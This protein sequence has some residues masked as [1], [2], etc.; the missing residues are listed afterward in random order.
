M[1]RAMVLALL[2][3]A[4]PMAAWADGIDLSNQFG[5]I[6]RFGT[7]S[8]S[9]SGIVSR[10]SQLVRFY[11]V[12]AAPGHSLGLV[13]FTTGALLSGSIAGGGTFAGGYGMSS[14]IVIGK[15]NWGE[16]KGTIFAGYFRSPITWTLISQ[17]G[18][19]LVFQLK[20]YVRGQLWNGR[21]VEFKTQ[22]MIVTTVWQLA[23]GR[24]NISAGRT[25]NGPEPA[26]LGLIATG[27]AGIAG[28]A[29]RRLL[30]SAK[31]S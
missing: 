18:P 28:V 1:K 11:D 2:A 4:V 10:G 27:L 17:H 16:P 8:I 21:M 23:R 9:N 7:I 25:A 15:G 24:G 20:G 29:R 6:N 13:A 5:I 31:R 19:N 30:A 26:T 12:V 3:L 14:F 22:Q